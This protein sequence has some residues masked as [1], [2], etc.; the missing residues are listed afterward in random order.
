[1]FSTVCFKY[2]GQNLNKSFL[3]FWF[4]NLRNNMCFILNSWYLQCAEDP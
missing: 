2:L 1:M 4:S 3:N